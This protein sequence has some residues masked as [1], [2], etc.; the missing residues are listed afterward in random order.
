MLRTTRFFFEQATVLGRLR[1]DGVI[2]AL[3]SKSIHHGYRN[4]FYSSSCL[5]Q[6]QSS[7]TKGNPYVFVCAC[8]CLC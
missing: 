4:F 1:C 6:S 5:V 8:S 3:V 7:I 2:V